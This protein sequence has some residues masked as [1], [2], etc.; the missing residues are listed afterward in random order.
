[1][2][3]LLTGRA[4][5]AYDRMSDCNAAVY[6]QVNAAILMRYNLAEEGRKF[7]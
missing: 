4:L 3:A 6:N 5:E 1:M 2:S 7:Q